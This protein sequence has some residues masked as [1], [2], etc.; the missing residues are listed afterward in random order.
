MKVN[1]VLAIAITEYADE[2]LNKIANCW[3]DVNDIIAI[4]NDKYSFDDI[5]F[6]F[7]K[8]ETTR[9]Y[10]Y[11][12]LT[13]YFS[14]TMPEDNVLFLFAGHGEYNASTSMAYWLPSDSDIQDPSSW[15]NIVEI[16]AFIR[17]SKSLHIG[18]IS[19]SCF[20]G[21]FF[22]LPKRGG[23]MNAL[24]TK[25]SREALTSGGIEKVSDGKEGER[26]PFANALIKVLNE[27]EKKELTF[28]VLAQNVILEFDQLKKQTPSFGSLNDVGH[29]GGTFIFELKESQELID[30]K[31]KFLKLQMG[32]LFIELTEETIDHI[33]KLI[34]IKEQKNIVIRGQRFEEAASLRDSEK[35]INSQIKEQAYKYIDSIS[36][37][38]LNTHDIKKA[39]ELEAELDLEVDRYLKLLE[40]RGGGQTNEIINYL[41]NIQEAS[42]IEQIHATNS[43]PEI[44][45]KELLFMFFDKL[46]PSMKFFESNREFF[47]KKYEASIID[48][49]QGFIKVQAESKNSMLYEKGKALKKILLKIYQYEI[50]ISQGR[51]IDYVNNLLQI[52]KIEIEIL[53]WMKVK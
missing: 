47:I 18:V 51:K 3:N 33:E 37:I 6:I 19:D 13:E 23:G 10:L 4:L 2:E 5:D 14:N 1:K 9:K 25:K 53:Q 48:L 28:N 26:S 46:D 38:T 21:A 45:E 35:M 40:E 31:N 32:N 49:Y 7:E 16:L 39:A 27:N 11:S 34:V 29:E 15:I 43:L 52:K 12:K 30:D 17:A 44:S 42:I 50:D 20:S 22:E 8:G 41:G 24:R 36:I